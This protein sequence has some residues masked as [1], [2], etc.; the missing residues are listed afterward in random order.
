MSANR[1]LKVDIPVVAARFLY[2]ECTSLYNFPRSTAHIASILLSE[3]N[4]KTR[5]P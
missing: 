3:A 1:K 4:H 5:F 2:L